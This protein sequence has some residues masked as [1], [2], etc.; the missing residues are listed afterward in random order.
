MRT[1][2]NK[3]QVEKLESDDSVLQTYSLGREQSIFKK[4]EE[5]LKDMFKSKKI[6]VK[7]RKQ[8]Y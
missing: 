1:L 8:R 5:K 7:P 6:K 2:P 3:R 4:M